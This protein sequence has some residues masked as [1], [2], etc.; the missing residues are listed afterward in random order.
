MVYNAA[1]SFK[2][3]HKV[4]SKLVT[5]GKFDGENYAIACATVGGKVSQRNSISLIIASK[6]IEISHFEEKA[7]FILINNCLQAMLS[8]DAKK[9]VIINL[10]LSMLLVLIKLSLRN[11]EQMK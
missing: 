4:L 1:F 6:R 2:V 11:I 3:P 9:L 7:I 10:G 8:L 5:I